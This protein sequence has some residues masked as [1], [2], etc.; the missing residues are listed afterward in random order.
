MRS[1]KKNNTQTNDNNWILHNTNFLFLCK[2]FDVEPGR[3]SQ[4]FRKATEKSVL[5]PFGTLVGLYITNWPKIYF[6]F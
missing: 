6:F 5:T 4:L 2:T 1:S 3:L